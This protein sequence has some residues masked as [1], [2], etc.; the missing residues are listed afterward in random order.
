MNVIKGVITFLVSHDIGW[1]VL[2]PFSRLGSMMLRIRNEIEEGRRVLAEQRFQETLLKNAFFERKVLHGPFKGLQ[3]PA[4]NAIG[5]S[6]YP[7][8]LGSYERELH[9]VM[10]QIL[11]CE[12]SEIINIGCAEG[13][14]AIGLARRFPTAKIIACDTDPHALRLCHQMASLNQVT[15][16]VTYVSH[17]TSSDLSNF[18]FSMRGLIVCDCEGYEQLLFTSESVENLKGCY[19]LIETHDFIDI[20]ITGRLRELFAP[21]HHVTAIKSLDDIEKTKLYHYQE[22]EGADLATR[23]NVIGER[24]PAIME[25]F[26]MVPKLSE[27]NV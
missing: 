19:L 5:S 10:D 4:F 22:L 8:L 17:F 2:K 3:Y 6:L 21:S 26:F 23:K 13:Y 11:A 9:G 7:K 16:K 25:W 15:N 1:F 24:R 27:K 20:R 18:S 14:Y 12:F